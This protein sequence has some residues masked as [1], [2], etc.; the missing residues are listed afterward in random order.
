MVAE[1]Y[2]PL[3]LVLGRSAC[4]SF[5]QVTEREVRHWRRRTVGPAAPR[6]LKRRPS[7]PSASNAARLCRKFFHIWRSKQKKRRDWQRFTYDAELQ[8]LAGR[9]STPPTSS[10]V[11]SF[12][13][14]LSVL[15]LI[16]CSGG[17]TCDCAVRPECPPHKSFS[18]S[19][20]ERFWLATATQ[21]HFVLYE[22]QETRQLG[23]D[24]GTNW[25]YSPPK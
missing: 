11:W 9:E 25:I 21:L 19:R 13:Q 1:E 3:L 7:R 4:P 23:R 20:A 16:L 5:N 15:L 12:P 14:K 17:L 22:I 8:W 18:K 10:T 6:R 24:Y 2:W